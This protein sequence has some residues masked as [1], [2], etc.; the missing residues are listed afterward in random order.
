VLLLLLA[1]TD[2]EPVDSDSDATAAVCAERPVLQDGTVVEVL[3][4]GVAVVALGGAFQADQ[5]PTTFV[6]DG[7]RLVAVDLPGGGD[8]PGEAD[9]F[10]DASRASVASALRYAAGMEADAD[11][12]SQPTGPVLLTALSNGGNLAVSTLADP[13]LELPV[14]AGLVVWETPI[15]PQL[16]LVEG[17]NPET[18]ACT[19]EDTLVCAFDGSTLAADAD[20][21]W[22]DRDGNGS[23]DEGEPT[24]RGLA[25]GDRRLH[26]PVLAAQ[27]GETPWTHTVET[28]S[29]WFAWR[30]AGRRAAEAAAR[31]P[32]MAVIVA[33]AEEDHVQT[34]PDSPHVYSLAQQFVA[35]GL[36]VRLNPDA[37]I[38]GLGVD[39]PGGS[40]TG[41]L[42][43]GAMS[44]GF[45][46]TAAAKELILRIEGDNWE[47]QL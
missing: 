3:G 23:L 4:E 32:E 43:P 42:V 8:T 5:V 22:L 20:T 47:P 21:T 12:C 10:G 1:C 16:V 2:R 7:Y 11:G 36:W 30:D 39:N 15:G 40:G 41:V 9:R 27:L 19:M 34:L 44:G 13:A 6:P 31:F 38:T 37:D 26:S 14:V 35:A 25:V 29:A 17:D 45:L 28:S 46:M 24:F 18:G 33:G